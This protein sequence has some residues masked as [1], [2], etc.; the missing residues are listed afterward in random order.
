MKLIILMFALLC[1]W[2]KITLG[3]RNIQFIYVG[4]GKVDH[5]SVVIGSMHFPGGYSG[6]K[7]LKV[8]YTDQ[9]T[10]DTLRS[11]I[12]HSNFVKESHSS[13]NENYGIDTLKLL[14]VYKIIGVAENPLYVDG[15]VCFKLFLSTTRYL[16][17]V[18]LENTTGWNAMSDMMFQCHKG[19]LHRNEIRE[20][21][22]QIDMPRMVDTP[23]N[24]AKSNH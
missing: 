11:Y 8:Y 4:S 12:L 7:H 1:G 23:R 2:A 17:Y 14:D 18:G 22:R 16:N 10:L 3:Q 9:R 15:I 13:R 24:L 20:S 21:D 5:D 6:S 19:F